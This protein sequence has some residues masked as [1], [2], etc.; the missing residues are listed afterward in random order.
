MTADD[1][2][3]W[4]RYAAATSLE[5]ELGDPRDAR[6]PLGFAAAAG[7][8][9]G[10]SRPA[11]LAAQ[12]GPR[13]RTAFVPAALG[14]TLE[15]LDAT[16]MLVRTAARRDAAIMPATMFGITAAT[17]V[18]I[19]G[20]RRQRE[21]VVGLL[22]E[23]GSLGFALSEADHGSDL[24]ANDTRAEE[25]P[26]G[27]ALTGEKW[28]VGL[29]GRC[30]GLLVVARTGGRGPAAFSAL[31]LDGEQAA[32]ARRDTRR[33]TGMRGADLAGFRFDGLTVPREALV[34]GVGR[35][36][37]TAMKA[38]QVVRTMSTAANL[39]CADT[40]LRLALDFAAAHVAAGRA[41]L[42]HPGVRRE[43]ATAAA[44]L[45]AADAV[46][47]TTARGLHTLPAA[48]SLWS[49]VAKKVLTDTC[50]EALARCADVLGSRGVLRDGPYAAFD[51]LRRDNAVVRHI[52]TSPTANLRLVAAH[53]ARLAA[54]PPAPPATG[55]DPGTADALPGALARTCTLSESLPEPDLDRLALSDRGA[56]P[57]LGAVP[58]VAARV[59]EVLEKADERRAA[60][61]VT[62][63]ERAASW[64]GHALRARRGADPLRDQDLAARLCWVHA[65]AS[66]LLL[67]WHNRDHRLY[68]A[69]G[70]DPGW[71]TA[72]LTVLTAR[73]AGRSSP[74]PE[75]DAEAVLAT[76]LPLHEADRLFSAAALPL[77][78]GG[79]VSASAPGASA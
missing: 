62:R 53:F 69:P 54:A 55:A 49:S 23:G 71:L 65:A 12:A 27:Y 14:G 72:A 52:D 3:R 31:L 42:A 32:A 64:L 51:T 4:P 56:D 5:R 29:G 63:L 2:Q 19:A 38:M 66:C 50:E 40:G 60:R 24:L 68:G 21:H 15:A 41:A 35:G 47:L 28:L 45:L 20:S 22:R 11:A 75:E 34:G 67:W 74:L 79:P 17:C 36:L 76:V 48:Q 33:P 44:L 9:A 25:V 30:D 61:A 70:G 39:G 37:E 46:A 26:G 6:N 16:L 1:G 73:A 77:A 43:L 78:H 7:R 13:L 8:D 59:R 58:V 57:V 10:E 18:L